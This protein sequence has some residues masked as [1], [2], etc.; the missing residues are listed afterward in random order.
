MSR[1]NPA[2]KIGAMGSSGLIALMKRDKGLCHV[3]GQ[4]VR[5]DEASRDHLIPRS[6]GGSSARSNLA[7][8]HKWCNNQRGDKPT[9][10]R[11]TPRGWRKPEPGA[12]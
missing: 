11:A 10:T 7:L 5:L 3:C 1:K 4:G 12:Q 9:K 2:W 6:A 8:A